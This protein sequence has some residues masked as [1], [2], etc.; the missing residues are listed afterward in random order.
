MP[1]CYCFGPP[2]PDCPTHGVKGPEFQYVELFPDGFWENLGI[3]QESAVPKI[4]LIDPRA[5]CPFGCQ[6]RGTY[7][8]PTGLQYCACLAGSRAW[9]LDYENGK[10]KSVCEVCGGSGTHINAVEWME[11]CSCSA[12]RRLEEKDREAIKR[13]AEEEHGKST[14]G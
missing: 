2:V 10:S 3:I 14:R 7:D 5:L 6:D 13:L 12:G 1:D 11:Y 4:N 8:S 9:A